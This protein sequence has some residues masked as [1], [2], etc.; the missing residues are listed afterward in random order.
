MVSF[1]DLPCFFRAATFS[2]IA[3]LL[4]QEV[5]EA[6][7]DFFPVC[8]EREA[9]GVQH[10]GF[11][12]LQIAQR[13]LV[14]RWFT[15]RMCKDRDLFAGRKPGLTLDGYSVGRSGALCQTYHFLPGV[16]QPICQG[17]DR[18]DIAEPCA[19]PEGVQV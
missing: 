9:T 13:R 14:V 16:E 17:L 6:G 2:R 15:A 18:L 10:V 5:C 8:L 4:E 11:D 12:V 19:L 7:G 1:K 3:I